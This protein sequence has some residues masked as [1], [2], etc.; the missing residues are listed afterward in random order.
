MKNF[1]Q[2]AVVAAS[3]IALTACKPS[4]P[5][6]ADTA[7]DEAVFHAATVTWADAYNAGNVDRIVALYAEDAVLMPPDAPAASGPAAI[8]DFLAADIAA[9][10]SGGFIMALGDNGIG[11]SGNLGWH[12]GT[13]TVTNAAGVTVVTGKWVETWHKADGKWLMI[14]DI[15]NSDAPAA[16]DAPVAPAQ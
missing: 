13:F 5:P 8:H 4:A 12:D 16:A 7:A 3:F 15:W 1:T 9:A 11:V 6:A 2:A 14:R 10:K